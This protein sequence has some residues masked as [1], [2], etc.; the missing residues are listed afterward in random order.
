MNK[1][2]YPG[3]F[4]PVT[5]GHLDIIK[6]A[7][8]VFDRVIVSVAEDT[9]KNTLFSSQER[10]AMLSRAVKGIKGVEVESF[11]G[12]VIDYARRKNVKLVVRGLRMIS[13]FDYEFQMALTNR[14]LDDNIEIVFMMPNESFSYVSAKLIKEAA[15][16]GAKLKA[17]LP[18]FVEK[19][20]KE[21]LLKK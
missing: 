14:K 10:V 18:D 21:K 15:A 8:R 2:I 7:S 1:V 17:F 5:Y 3:T 12:L 19:A 9:S 13:D 4:D 11:D 16:L 20:L 6:R